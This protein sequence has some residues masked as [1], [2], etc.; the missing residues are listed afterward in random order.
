MAVA[1]VP[2]KNHLRNRGVVA[3]RHLGKLGALEEAAA[4]R[5]RL[6]ERAVGH[7]CHVVVAHP[8]QEV[9]LDSA[10]AGVVE[11]LVHLAVAS[12][13]NAPEFLHVVRVEV[14]DAPGADLALLHE[15]LHAADGLAQGHAAAPVEQV[16]VEVVAAEGLE[17]VVAGVEDVGLAGVVGQHLRDEVELVAVERLGVRGVEQ[18]PRQRV[19]DEPLAAPV[20]IHLGRVDERHAVRDARAQGQRLG[21]VRVTMV[22]HVPRALAERGYDAAVCELDRA[23]R[24][25]NLSCHDGSLL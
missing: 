25:S 14:R 7:E 21:V 11:H 17:R 6:R 16:E 5:S 9:V 10:R 13:G 24:G 2:G 3:A 8:G 15:L 20:A 23:R 12:L 18:M 4:K 1:D 19:A 22:A